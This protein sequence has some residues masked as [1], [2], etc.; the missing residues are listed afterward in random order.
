MGHHLLVGHECEEWFSEDP[1]EA[2]HNFGHL[3]VQVQSDA[4]GTV[5]VVGSGMDAYDQ[6][7]KGAISFQEVA[8]YENADTSF[9][10]T[11]EFAG[12]DYEYIDQVV[13]PGSWTYRV[14]VR[15]R[16]GQVQVVDQKD[17]VIGQQ[18]GVDNTVSSALFLGGLFFVSAVSYF[19]DLPPEQ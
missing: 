1:G 10:L 2:V 8:T 13:P 15:F 3:G 16:D 19:A 4:V 12:G 9:L 5:S 18:S 6:W 14:L 17:V 7:A 11:K